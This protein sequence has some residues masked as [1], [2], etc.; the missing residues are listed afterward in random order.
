MAD[1]TVLIAPQPLPRTTTFGRFTRRAPSPA[2]RPIMV[3]LQPA[4]DDP[5]SESSSVPSSPVSKKGTLLEHNNSLLSPPRNTWKRPKPRP[6][7]RHIHTT[8]TAYIHPDPHAQ[9]LLQ[10]PKSTDTELPPRPASAP[11]LQRKFQLADIEPQTPQELDMY[12]G[13]DRKRRSSILAEF[14]AASTRGGELLRPAPP[15]CAFLMPY[16]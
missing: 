10:E 16:S 2:S 13:R 8:P 6:P 11:P 4:A 5:H 15:L 7:P 9:G 12:Y 3:T 14:A 1:L